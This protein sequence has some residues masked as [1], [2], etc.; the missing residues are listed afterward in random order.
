MAA[1]G[2]SEFSTKDINRR[3]NSVLRILPAAFGRLTSLSLELARS[4]DDRGLEPLAQMTSLKHLDLTHRGNITDKGLEH[5]CQLASLVTLKLTGCYRITDRGLARISES[6]KFLT[7]LHL[8]AMPRLTAEGVGSLATLTHL[9][10][11]K[12]FGCAQVR[13][14]ALAFLG[15]ALVELRSLDLRGCMAMAELDR[16]AVQRLFPNVTQLLLP[17]DRNVL[18]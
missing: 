9:Q 8:G 18:A 2:L 15:P 16:L 7:V 12:L 10:E 17:A 6:L 14:E 1:R 11:L 5:V 3:G 4:V 13:A